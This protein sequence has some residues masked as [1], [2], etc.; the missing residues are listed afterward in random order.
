MS[1]PAKTE[2]RSQGGKAVRSHTIAP[3]MDFSASLTPETVRCTLKPAL[4][5]A[6]AINGCKSWTPGSKSSD[7]AMEPPSSQP[8]LVPMDFPKGQENVSSP[9]IAVSLFSRH[10]EHHSDC[11][12]VPNYNSF[13]ANEIWNLEALLH[14]LNLT[15]HFQGRCKLLE[16]ETL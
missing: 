1:Y 4:S 10:G 6:S 7:S 15:W 3:E 8:F 11:V 16:N 2:A 14:T 5:I 13:F 9:I 12:Y